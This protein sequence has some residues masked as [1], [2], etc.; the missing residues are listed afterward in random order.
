M[1]IGSAHSCVLC[2]AGSYNTTYQDQEQHGSS[3][4]DIS[5]EQLVNEY[6]STKK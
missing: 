2:P 4:E 5:H 3:F 1:I 6:F